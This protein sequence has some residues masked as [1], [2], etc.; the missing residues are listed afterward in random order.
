MDIAPSFDPQPPSG[1]R[2]AP[3][4]RFAINYI[5]AV[6][7]VITAVACLGVLALTP[8][9]REGDWQAR[10]GVKESLEEFKFRSAISTNAA[11]LALYADSVAEAYFEANDGANYKRWQKK[12]EE[13]RARAAKEADSLKSPLDSLESPRD[14]IR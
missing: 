4:R 11:E 3:R 14:L 13:F 10:D 5:I 1:A 2:R 8:R 7:V 12:A 9:S 6:P